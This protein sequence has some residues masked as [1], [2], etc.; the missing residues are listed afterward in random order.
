MYTLEVYQRSAPEVW[1]LE[2]T[3]T[4]LTED[5]MIKLK[6]QYERNWQKTR[7]YKQRENDND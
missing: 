5:E 4:N 3:V 7:V 1:N 2:R 6:R